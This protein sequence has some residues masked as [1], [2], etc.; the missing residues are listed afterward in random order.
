[1]GDEYHYQE[2]REIDAKLQEAMGGL[3]DAF[4]M[5]ARVYGELWSEWHKDG[6]RDGMWNC[7]NDI[8]AAREQVTAARNS[9]DLV[10]SGNN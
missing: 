5:A 6:L 2:R 3:Q 7:I 1:M 8:K 4:D 9:L 10:R